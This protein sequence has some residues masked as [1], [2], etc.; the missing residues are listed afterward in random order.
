MEIREPEA[1][2]RR[3]VQTT[4]ELRCELHPHLHLNNR[5]G[6]RLTPSTLPVKQEYACSFSELHLA[7]LLVSAVAAKTFVCDSLLHQRSARYKELTVMLPRPASRLPH[8]LGDR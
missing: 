2:H 8:S 4:M 6:R 1:M 3:D 5:A 7:L